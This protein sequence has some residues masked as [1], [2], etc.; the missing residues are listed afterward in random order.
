MKQAWVSGAG[1][2]EE[3][4]RSFFVRSGITSHKGFSQLA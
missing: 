2:G 3:D 1:H 4:G